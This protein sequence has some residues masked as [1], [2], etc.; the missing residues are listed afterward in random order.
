MFIVLV[1]GQ[2]IRCWDWGVELHLSMHSLLTLNKMWNDGLWYTF[3]LFVCL[4][5]PQRQ[6]IRLSPP[7]CSAFNLA[8]IVTPESGL[9]CFHSHEKKSNSFNIYILLSIVEG[10]QVS[11]LRH[12]ADNICQYPVKAIISP[13]GRL[14]FKLTPHFAVGK[15]TF[16]CALPPPEMLCNSKSFCFSPITLSCSVHISPSTLLSKSG[17]RE[18]PCGKPEWPTDAFD[19]AS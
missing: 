6:N 9:Q 4:Q 1:K 7:N 14:L 17:L 19:L 2:L 16:F 5:Q 13:P 18:R 3:C 8:T 11:K 15:K 12:L 10:K